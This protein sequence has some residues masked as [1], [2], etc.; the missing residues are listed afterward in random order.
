MRFPSIRALVTG[1]AGFIG[2]HLAEALCQ[3]GAE[4]IVLDNLSSGLE[5]NLSWRRT[6]HRLRFVQ[7]DIRDGALV[8]R[9]VEGCDWVFHQAAI[10]SVPYSVEHPVETNEQNL[11]ATLGLLVAARE[12]GV[13]RFLFASSSAIYGDG[14]EP[15]KHEALPPLPVSPYALQKYA[16][17]RYGQL[18][19]ALY[20]FETVA[21]RYFN[22]FGPRQVFDSPYSGVIARF[23]TAFLAGERPTV[24]GDG[25]QSR[26]FISVADVAR[27]NLAAAAAPAA[28]V[29]GRI[30]N[31]AGGRSVSLLELVSS[32]NELTGQGLEPV[33]A[34][35][36]AGDVRHSQADIA[37]ARAAFG[38]AA[39]VSL[40]EG[41]RR[42]LDFYR[43]TSSSRTSQ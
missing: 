41:L 9:V 8:R 22:V 28:Q 37:A 31:I 16:S 21:L 15:V 10:A 3:E 36:R 5:T 33:F 19:H 34:P 2:S 4:V 43:S 32:L 38:F 26:D 25:L 12:A 23:C 11:S 1:G 13:R 30:F 20:G 6:P 18:L 14:A 29:A 40:D 17:E 7:G 35:A 42:T 39:T 27:A 24:F